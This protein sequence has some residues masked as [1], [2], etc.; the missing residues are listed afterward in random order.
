MCSASVSALKVASPSTTSPIASLTTSSK[1]DMCAPFW[2]GPRSTTHSK[3]A[4]NSCSA[5][6][7]SQPDH[8]LDAGHADAREAE[9]DR[10]ASAPARRAPASCG[11]RI[12]IAIAAKGSERSALG[13]PVRASRE[14]PCGIDITPR[15]HA[16]VC[17][18]SAA[19]RGSRPQ[20]GS[21]PRLRRN[22]E[23]V[24]AE[25]SCCSA[26]KL[27]SRSSTNCGR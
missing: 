10:R 6:F 3:R 20:G 12:G 21:R 23:A 7:C 16:R 17:S 25:R 22:S 5:P 9:R 19:E 15:S 26:T 27:R 24:S 2:S 4:E 1:R 8:L 14:P 18:L 11:L 13:R